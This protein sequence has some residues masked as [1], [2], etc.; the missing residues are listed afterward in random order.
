MSRALTHQISQ[1]NRVV[2][3]TIQ[4]TQPVSKYFFVRVETTVPGGRTDGPKLND[5]TD[6]WP[7][8]MWPKGHI[9]ERQM[10]ELTYGLKSNDRTTNDRQTQDRADIWP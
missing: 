3:I 8:D 2:E 1:I 10:T 9:S 4:R 6:K 7:K 5:G